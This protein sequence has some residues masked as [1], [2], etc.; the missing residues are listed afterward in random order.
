MKWP[1]SPGKTFI[2]LAILSK[3]DMSE[4]D[5]FTEE[6]I[7]RGD[8]DKIL[9]MKAPIQLADIFKTEKIKCVLVE[10]APGMG[11]STLA[12]H[13]CQQWGKGELFQEFSTVQLLQLRDARVQAATC[14]E[15]LFPHYD[16][17]LQREAAQKISNSHGEGTLIILDGLDELP[18]DRLSP[19]Y[20]FPDLLSGKVLPRAVIMITSRPSATYTLWKKWKQQ[21][22]EHIEIIGFT[23]D[24]IDEYVESVLPPEMLPQ[25]DNY[26][27]MHPHIELMMYVPLHCAIVT[28]VYTE[29]QKS[30]RPP[31]RTLTGLYT[32]LTQTILIRYLNDHPD[33]KGKNYCLNSFSN[34]PPPVYDDFKKLCQI[35]FEG[36][37]AQR[38]V[39]R[40]LPK[41]TNHLGFMA[42]VP[43]MTLYEQSPSYS[44]NFLHLSVQEFLAA[45]YVSLM[46]PQEQEQLL[47]SLM[48]SNY[49][50]PI[51]AKYIAYHCVNIVRF[52]AGLTH[53]QD[54]NKVVVR[55]VIGIKCSVCT[56]IEG[57]LFL[58]NQ[59]LEILHESQNVRSILE[60]GFHYAAPMPPL[61]S[62]SH[63]EYV[64]LAYSI[65]NSCSKW[66]LVFKQ[67]ER[68][69][70]DEFTSHNYD[71]ADLKAF[72]Q[73]LTKSN[74]FTIINLIC[75]NVMPPEAIEII[76][77]AVTSLEKLVMK[78]S[79][80]TLQI[81][82]NLASMLQQ[83]STATLKIMYCTIDTGCICQLAMA[84]HHNTAL[85]VLVLSNNKVD[86]EGAV[87]IAEMLKNNKTLKLLDMSYNSV[88]ERGALA[89]AEALNCNTT[90]TEL[91]MSKNT[92]GN[93]GVLAIADALKHNTVLMGLHLQVG[94]GG[95]PAMIKALKHNTTLTELHMTPNTANVKGVLEM[96]EML[97]HNTTLKILILRDFWTYKEED[98][99]QWPWLK[100]SNTTQH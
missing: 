42:A 57:V 90:L 14:V 8:V 81:T 65:A 45:Y 19:P 30:R 51:K 91:N 75:E 4:V 73:T 76:F 47:Q 61:D 34:L 63:H 68:E 40:D 55:R 52:V 83:N 16:K 33:Y 23:E 67:Y 12:W 43:E 37:L 64:A 3:E 29:C 28:I 15:D 48:V 36:V 78:K 86:D 89:M 25:F 2:N 27:S 41:N 38:L 59:I 92:V 6:T 31:P 7:L 98:V 54:L 100:W 18:N 94:D 20:I 87:A 85:T 24:D 35:A 70:G 17:K 62:Y 50:R 99:Q 96:A 44:H 5:E 79:L 93:D 9:K 32:C 71:Y 88:G 69:D 22:S 58:N 66:T 21:I 53:F 49:K 74:T 56:K 84:L 11:K 77:S 10:G 95:A 80:F 13:V 60:D 82:H 26:I 97:K 72:T 1:P 46:S 39:F